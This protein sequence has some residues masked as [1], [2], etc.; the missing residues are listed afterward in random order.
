MSNEYPVEDGFAED[1]VHSAGAGAAAD[2]ELVVAASG[3]GPD[4]PPDEYDYLLSTLGRTEEQDQRIAVHEAG[5]AVCA[6][7]LGHQVGGVTINPDP[8][9]GSEGLC[10]DVGHAEAYS[11]GHGDASD[12]RAVIAPMMP[13]AGEDRSPLADVFGSVYAKCIEFVAGRA[14][15]RLLLEGEPCHPIDDL[16]QARELALL[17]CSSDE[18]IETF[19]AHC[20][21]V[22]RDLLAP[23]G[24]V[25]MVLST[26]L[27]IKRTLHGR[28]IDE[29]ISDVVTRKAVATEKARRAAWRKSELE[30]SRFRAM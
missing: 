7:L 27:R 9:R 1:A 6:R 4:E 28:E 13:K 29:I 16:R 20:D 8:V 19:L 11:E 10:W 12:V 17:I 25:L 18:A 14:A 23:Y 15:E 5:H 2:A 30:A 24:D 26:V 3:G 21:V 22:A